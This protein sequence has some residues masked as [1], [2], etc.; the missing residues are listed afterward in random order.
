[1]FGESLRRIHS[2]STTECPYR[3]RITEMLEEIETKGNLPKYDL[4]I[5]PEGFEKAYNKL[6]QLKSLAEEDV[7]LHG[8][9]CLPNI[10]LKDFELKGFIDLGSGGVGDRHW[11]LFWGIWTLQYNLK[12]DKYRDIFLDAYGK[13][14]VDEE[15][16]EMC[17][18]IAGL[19]E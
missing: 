9:Y 2:L 11:D 10:I 16:L 15:R 5:I 18:L 1:V 12:T 19:T 4:E 8:D 17:R 3:H 14:E 13:R 6:N 7:V